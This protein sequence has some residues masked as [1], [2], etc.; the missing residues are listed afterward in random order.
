MLKASPE[1]N[2]PRA[3]RCSLIVPC[4]NEAA[5]IRDCLTSILRQESPPG[6]FEVLVVDGMSTDGT[7]EI[8]Q[9]ISR[10]DPRVRL[11]DNS[12]CFQSY[13][14]NL[15]IRAARGEIIL[16]LDAHTEYAPDYV[17]RAVETLENTGAQNV[18]GPTRAVG[19]SY[20]QKAVAAAFHSPFAV[21]WGRSHRLDYEGYVDTVTYGCWRKDTLIKVGLFDETLVRNQDD[22]LNLRII[23]AGG[24]IW[25]TPRIR[26]WYRPRNSLKALFHQYLQYGYW[27]VAVIRKH[28]QVAALRHIVPGAFVVSLGVFLLLAPFSYWARL[29]LT[30]L[31]VGYGGALLGASV[32]SCRTHGWDLLPI[33]PLTICCYHF[34]YGLG[35]VRGLIDFFLRRRDPRPIFTTLTR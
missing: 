21:G 35:F 14:M 29:F 20:I 17:R 16:R 27:K 24:K 9:E 11:L 34:G 12:G 3:P 25:Q 26:S 5:H 31:S 30:A 32:F 22:E 1:N 13:A 19:N 7:R 8:I 28:R 6:G 10:N 4:R 2:A 15:G 18:G 33:M 23:Q